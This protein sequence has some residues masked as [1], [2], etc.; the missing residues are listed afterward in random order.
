MMQ[1]CVDG[2]G[3]RPRCGLVWVL[4]P[5]RALTGAVTE[6]VGASPLWQLLAAARRDMSC[7]GASQMPQPGVAGD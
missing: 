2:G 4:R 6:E 7:T 1:R 5:F 3:S